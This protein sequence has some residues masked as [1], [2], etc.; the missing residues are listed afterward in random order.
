MEVTTIIAHVVRK[1]DIRL[2]EGFDE[3]KDL[4]WMD[5]FNSVLKSHVWAYVKERQL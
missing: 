1:I 3:E 5:V 4:M 2:Q